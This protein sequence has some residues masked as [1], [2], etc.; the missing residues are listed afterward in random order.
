MLDKLK[1]VNDRYEKLCKDICDSDI[2]ADNKL[3]QK[4]VKEHSDFFYLWCAKESLIKCM[5]SSINNIRDVPSLPLNGLKTYKGKDYQ[6]Q[7]FIYDKHI[8]SITRETNEEFTVDIEK[9][10][11]LS[12]EQI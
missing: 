7:A 9:I 6:C 3:W 8:V 1:V 4:L 11:K 2:I 12:Q 10:E 5:G